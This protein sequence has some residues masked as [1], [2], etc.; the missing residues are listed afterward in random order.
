VLMTLSGRTPNLPGKSISGRSGRSPLII[1]APNSRLAGDSGVWR[2]DLHALCGSRKWNILRA[3]R[4]KPQYLRPTFLQ[5]SIV[6]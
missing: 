3:R 5:K 6:A 4:T 1:G 2:Q